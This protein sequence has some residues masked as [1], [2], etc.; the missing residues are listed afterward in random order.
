M[1]RC[2]RA[3]V[4]SLT[5]LVVTAVLA[6]PAF[7]QQ[8]T[9]AGP[10]SLGRA[11]QVA[12]DN[13][14]L[15][16]DAEM[17]FQVAGQ[18][19][20]EA[21]SAVM[22]E[23]R[24]NASYARNLR[25]QEAFLPAI[26]FDPNASPTDLIP[27]RFGSDNTW[28]LGLTFDQPLFEAGVFI[29]VGAA[30]RYQELQAER[31]R[32]TAQQV[33]TAVRQAYFDALLAEEEVRLTENSIERVRRT[34]EET[35]AMNR[36]GLAS[37]Y[38][39]LRLEVQLG[40]LEPNLQRAVNAVA[41]AKRRLL[42][43]MGLDPGEPI[44]LEGSLSTMDLSAPDLNVQENAALLRV[45]GAADLVGGDLAALVPL[46]ERQR[47]DLRQLD[48][49]ISLEGSRLAVERAEY[50]PKLSVFSNYDITAQENGGLNF[51]GGGS[52]QRT[53]TT[54]AGLRVEVPIFIGFSRDARVRQAGARVRQNEARRERAEQETVSE[55]RT[56]LENVDEALARAAAQQR[57]V[58]Q[59]Q[60]GFEIASA[61]Y[62]AGVGSQLQITDAEVAL[63]ETEF[64]YAR[65]VYDYLTARAQLEA[66]VGDVPDRA[67]ALA[68]R[69]GSEQQ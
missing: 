24:A 66:A 8:A 54:V 23:V 32:G 39:V 45:T 3:A 38:D 40:N 16:E 19:V 6:T 2:V 59:A 12:L 37:A 9:G 65:A 60:R 63:R 46:A 15:L 49:N 42:V 61:E 62:N 22:P 34:L 64:N 68:L 14:R 5:A 30:A 28:R 67:G 43:E 35:R 36:A 7:P 56:A 10:I 4:S 25:V 26:I 13:S 21:W 17:E 20:R 58:A 11:I 51:F 31:V 1:N 27:V 18:Q 48:A 55:V 53:A 44:V 29:G 33:V 52:N 50:F 57:A 69:M 41:A 47:S